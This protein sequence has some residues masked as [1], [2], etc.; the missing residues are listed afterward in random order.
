VLVVTYCP[1]SGSKK[2]NSIGGIRSTSARFARMVCVKRLRLPETVPIGEVRRRD[3]I[4]RVA[5]D[6]DHELDRIADADVGR[7]GKR[8]DLE[9]PDGAGERGRS[10]FGGNRLD[11]GY[12][13]A[14]A[15]PQ[16]SRAGDAQVT[17]D[18]IAAELRG[19]VHR[20]VYAVELDRAGLIDGDLGGESGD[21]VEL[22]GA[23]GHPAADTPVLLAV[24]IER[25]DP[26][27]EQAHHRGLFDQLVAIDGRLDPD[28][29]RERSPLADEEPILVAGDLRHEQFVAGIGGGVVARDAGSRALGQFSR[30]ELMRPG[31]ELLAVGGDGDGGYCYFAAGEWRERVC[32]D[33]GFFAVHPSAGLAEA[34]TGGLPDVADVAVRDFGQCRLFVLLAVDQS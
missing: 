13:D 5:A 26:P 7:D 9:S 28:G 3:G 12:G 15:D 17:P 30:H 33:S 29:Q 16:W 27:A 2:A 34:G 6:V 23:V 22:L 4:D 11:F 20:E 19:I 18:A 24:R 32:E 1:A 14:R 25:L 21:V 8:V 31:R 10:I